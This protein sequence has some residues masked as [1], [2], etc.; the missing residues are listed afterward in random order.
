MHLMKAFV[1]VGVLGLPSA[2]RH[3]G[4]VVSAVRVNTKLTVSLII[5]V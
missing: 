4:L 3:T 2:V 1:G 5:Y